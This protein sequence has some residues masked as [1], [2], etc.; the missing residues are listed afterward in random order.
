MI[1]MCIAFDIRTARVQ[2]RGF[3]PLTPVT[4]PPPGEPYFLV[5]Y[6]DTCAHFE[7]QNC[8]LLDVGVWIHQGIVLS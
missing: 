7:L 2:C 1:H 8:T 3:A 4:R 5:C 6:V